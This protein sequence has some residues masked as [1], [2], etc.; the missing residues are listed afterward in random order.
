MEMLEDVE[1]VKND[2]AVCP[3]LS[4]GSQSP[5]KQVI[6]YLRWTFCTPKA[7]A[8]IAQLQ[9]RSETDTSE[10]VGELQGRRVCG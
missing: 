10:C 6:S 1:V 8:P 4:S 9:G 5:Y 7:E 3:E 2:G